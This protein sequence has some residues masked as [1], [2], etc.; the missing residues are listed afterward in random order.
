MFILDSVI[1]KKSLM[2]K[3]DSIVMS[4]LPGIGSINF[5]KVCMACIWFLSMTYVHLSK[6]FTCIHNIRGHK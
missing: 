2:P 4:M 6:T 1:T 5:H 3:I